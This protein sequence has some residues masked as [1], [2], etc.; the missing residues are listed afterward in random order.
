M[1]EELKVLFYLKK[2][3]VNANGLCSVM[4]RITIG[5][6]M[7]QFSAKI[8][9]EPSK[10]DAKAGRIKFAPATA[11]YNEDKQINSLYILQHSLLE[12]QIHLIYDNLGYVLDATNPVFC[13]H[14]SIAL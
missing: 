9:A 14:I 11:N 1:K 12:W 10:W 3:Q 8:E 5:R 4:G 2:N 7:A 6:S 13:G